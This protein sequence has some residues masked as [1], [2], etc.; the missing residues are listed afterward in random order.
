MT[1]NLLHGSLSALHVV[2][3][4]RPTSRARAREPEAAGETPKVVSAESCSFL[5]S[6]VN[7]LSDQYLKTSFRRFRFPAQ[8]RVRTATGFDQ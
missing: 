5:G 8:N 1:L 2:I 6:E 7:L 4:P 3:L